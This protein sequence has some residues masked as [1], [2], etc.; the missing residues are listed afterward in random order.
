MWWEDV[1]KRMKKLNKKKA[2][3]FLKAE[4]PH[5]HLPE[6]KQTMEVELNQVS[7]AKAT[8]IAALTILF[9]IFLYYIGGILL[10][11]F[12]AFLFAAVLYPLVD[13]L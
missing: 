2:L 6:K 13:F 1:R 4:V 9:F 5:L 7:V 11:F 8:A 12:I 10:L 3:S